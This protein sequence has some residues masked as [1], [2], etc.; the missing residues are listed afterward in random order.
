M[1]VPE[2]F[3]IATKLFNG[4]E[5]EVTLYVYRQR[6]FFFVHMVFFFRR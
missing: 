2:M 5:I 4:D 3:D 6:S 1:G